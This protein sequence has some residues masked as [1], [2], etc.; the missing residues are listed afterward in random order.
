MLSARFFSVDRL[1]DWMRIWVAYYGSMNCMYLLPLKPDGL[2][3]VNSS[4]AALSNAVR[5]IQILI[6][7]SITCLVIFLK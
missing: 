7:E 2:G 1:D 6:L 5:D 3:I 4:L